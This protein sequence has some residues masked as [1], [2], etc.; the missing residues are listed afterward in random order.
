MTNPARPERPDR[1]SGLDMVPAGPAPPP[2]PPRS[3]T[4]A[5]GAGSQPPG[6]VVPQTPILAKETY[7]APLSYIGSTRRIAS[8]IKRA[9]AGSPI[10]AGFAWSGGV[11]AIL[12]TWVFVTIWYMITLLLFGVFMFPYRLIRRS[13]RKQEHMQRV[14]LATMQA[15]MVNQQRALQEKEPPR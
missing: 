5:W 4:Q 10:A 7:A 6:P 15:M 3:S 9:G 2:T 12:L 13:H 11:V 1:P 14:Q 8:W